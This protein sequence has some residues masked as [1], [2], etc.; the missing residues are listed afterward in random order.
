MKIALVKTS[1]LGDIVH[2]FDT[3]AFLRR[4]FPEAEIDWLVERPFAPLVQAHPFVSQV[5]PVDTKQ[6]RKNP[7]GEGTRAFRKAMRQKEYDVIFDLQGNLKSGLVLQMMQGRRKVGFAR[8]SLPEL[9]NLFFTNERYSVDRTGNIRRSYLELV[10][11]ALACQAPETLQ[12]A[13]LVLPEEEQEKV[14]Q[15]IASKPR[16]LCVASLFS[17]WPNKELAFSIFSDFLRFLS[18]KYG[19]SFLLLYGN[20]EEKK[21]ALLLEKNHHNI[22]TVCEKL[23]FPALQHLIWGA[24]LYVGMDSFPLHLA[25]TT[26]TPIFSCFGPSNASVYAPA[27]EAG[28]SLQGPCPFEVAFTSRCPKLRTCATGACIK[29][30]TFE[31]LAS[32]FSKWWKAS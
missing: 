26:P 19:F 29:N 2:T 21:K 18:Q 14:A 23:S 31:K 6:W 7:F 15:L 32:D 9:P 28:F 25:G 12:G 27:G 1:S 11:K 5:I 24:D 20:E 4:L 3:L 22:A 10:E 13:K 17:A 8:D 16:P 30:I